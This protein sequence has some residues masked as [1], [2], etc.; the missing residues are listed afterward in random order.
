MNTNAFETYESVV[1]SYCRHFPKVFTEATDRSTST[2]S[3][4]QAP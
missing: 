3:A 1:R 2:F 4:A